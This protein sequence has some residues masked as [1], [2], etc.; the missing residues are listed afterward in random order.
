MGK[1]TL[2]VSIGAEGGSIALY[3]EDG[4]STNRRFRV[5]IVDQSNPNVPE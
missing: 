2:L 5:M 1:A 4:D 3:G